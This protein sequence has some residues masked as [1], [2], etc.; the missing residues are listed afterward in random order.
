MMVRKQRG[1][2]MLGKVVFLSSRVALMAAVV[3]YAK[4]TSTRAQPILH[5]SHSH[6][7]PSVPVRRLAAAAAAASSS[8][9][10]AVRSALFSTAPRSLA[11]AAAAAAPHSSG[12]NGRATSI[13]AP[14]RRHYGSGFARD[15]PPCASVSCR[16]SSLLS[17]TAP[18]TFGFR[19]SYNYY[20]TSSPALLQSSASALLA[21][22]LTRERAEEIENDTLAVPSELADLRA[23]LEAGG[24]GD[25]GG[26]GW[27]IVDVGATTRLTKPLP[28]RGK[29]VVHFHCQDIIEE[30]DEDAFDD[31]DEDHVEAEG[32]G[33]DEEAAAADDEE[34]MAGAVRFV[35]AVSYPAQKTLVFQCVTDFGQVQIRSASTTSQSVDELFQQSGGAGGSAGGDLS[36]GGTG[37]PR[38]YQGPVF[39]ELA[40]DLQQAFHQ[41]LAQEVGVNEDVAAFVSMHA[42]H[43]EQASY[44]KFLD[45]CHG[46][47]K[48]AS[49]SSASSS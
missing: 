15:L 34:E 41:Y 5:H 3:T 37:D 44:V 38:D 14:T 45:E 31:H 33:D 40:Q 43:R 24:G 13:G 12:R 21:D 28:S 19:C 49:S 2:S 1:C 39:D 32:A 36:G 10:V 9:A 20:S 47:V 30:L 42:D 18:P 11:A 16:P 17:K 4:V 25:S 22:I 7:Q 35:V 8:R 23:K 26:G 46:V 29:A 6:S 27:K 48:A